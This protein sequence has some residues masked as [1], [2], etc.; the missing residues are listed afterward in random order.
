MIC[1]SE[2]IQLISFVLHVFQ[3]SFLFA[4]LTKVFGRMSS[5]SPPLFLLKA[6]ISKMTL[7]LLP[8][9]CCW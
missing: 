9:L 2:M 8:C 4:S 6:V 1:V 5:P 7:F 3:Q